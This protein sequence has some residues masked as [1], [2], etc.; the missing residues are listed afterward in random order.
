MGWS[1]LENKPLLRLAGWGRMRTVKVRKLFMG[2]DNTIWYMKGNK[3][4]NSKAKKLSD[5]KAGTLPLPTRR[6]MP[7]HSPILLLSMI[8][9]G[10]E[11][12]LC[13]LEWAAQ[14]CSPSKPLCHS[15]PTCKRWGA[16]WEIKMA[17][18][19]HKH[20]SATAKTLV[21]YQPCFGHNPKTQH[22]TGCLEE[23]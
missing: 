18:I 6:P 9:E 8:L 1:W 19:L 4:T 12:P 5:A 23:K 15:Q 14:G 21:C 17:L 3:K 20:G 7:S 13:Q 22:H 16:E 10:M 11:Y 2:W